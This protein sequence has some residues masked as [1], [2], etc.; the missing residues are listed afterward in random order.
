[1]PD[2]SP[3]DQELV[4]FLH[5]AQVNP[6][7]S[8]VQFVEEDVRI[9]PGAKHGGERLRFDRQPIQRVFLQELDREYWLDVVCTGPSQAGKTMLCFDIPI[10]YYTAERKE[11]VVVGVPDGAMVNDKWEKEI[12]KIFDASPDLRQLIPDTGAG[13]R[14]GKVKE[15]V[16][17]TNDGSMRFMTRGGSNQSKAGFT[18]R[19]VIV[20]EASGWTAGTETSAE[21]DPLEQLRARQRSW[22]REERI[23]IIEGT[24]TV[25]DDYPWS[26]FGTSSKSR[27]VSPCPHC[28]EWIQ[29]E[30]DNLK[31]WHQATSED[32][33]AASAYFECPECGDAIDDELRNWSVQQVRILH[34]DQRVDRKGQVVGEMPTS[35]RLWFRWSGWH[36]LFSSIGSLAVDEWQKLQ[37]PPDS[38]QEESAERKLCQFV[39]AIPYEPNL[40]DSV[41]IDAVKIAGRKAEQ[42][43]HDVLPEDTTHLTIGIDIGKRVGHYV[44]MAGRECGRIH[45]PDYG[46]FGIAGDK[47]DLQ[48]AIRN[49]LRKFHDRIV[50]P[51]FVIAN[52]GGEAISPGLVYCDASYQ[53]HAV[54]CH[55]KEA[56]G[57]KRRGQWLPVFGRGSGQ[58]HAIYTAPKKKGGGIVEIGDRWHV[59]RDKKFRGWA[60]MADVD[61]WK[62]IIH[63]HLSIP[64]DAVGGMTLYAAPERDHQRIAQHFAAEE[65][66]IVFEPGKGSKVVWD[67]QGKQ[68]WFDSAV[69]ARAAL[70]R[71][72]WTPDQKT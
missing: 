45:I 34:G 18:A 41:E 71:L 28:G 3:I 44:V 56:T 5:A 68:H 36:N 43:G 60:A 20:T 66:K 67:R 2:L 62:D 42:Y 13:S 22:D 55:W 58:M 35:R 47:M 61:H 8:M 31:G 46:E 24:G 17:L 59:F 37:C 27:L 38:L 39:W 52:S 65:R 7:R 57:G 32:E 4:W 15:S 33:A 72:G 19:V 64:K 63:G 29:P 6:F 1:M 12:K 9:P 48:I 40:E 49:A 26:L 21:A 70:S 30:R 69:Y 53:A 16:T 11:T 14:G 10:A 50:D 51:G 23:T 54:F 25:K